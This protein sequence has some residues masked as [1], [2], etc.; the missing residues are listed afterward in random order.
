MD[1]ESFQ[2]YQRLS[3]PF[4]ETLRSS[5]FTEPD[6][7]HHYILTSD[8]RCPHL[9]PDGLCSLILELGE[10]SLCEICANHPRFFQ[11]F[12]DVEEQG[13]GIACEEA[14]RLLFTDPNP[15]TLVEEGHDEGTPFEEEALYRL[16]LDWRAECLAA[17]ADGE[18]SIY[19]RLGEVLSLGKQADNALWGAQWDTVPPEVVPGHALLWLD[20]LTELESV[21]EEWTGA[22]E[23]AFA[24]AEYPE[25]LEE[26]ALDAETR[27][28]DRLLTYYLFRF[29]LE[30]VWDA[31]AKRWADFIVFAVLTV[32]LLDFGRW[33]KNGCRF[34]SQDRQ[35][36]ARIFAKEFEYDSELA[37]KLDG[38]TE[39]IAIFGSVD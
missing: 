37:E 33:L 15:L 27:Q 14:A 19:E 9:R 31:N 36:I 1:E 24:A 35:D 23:D 4:G 6:G 29:A 25:L 22:L 10:E 28:Y 5:I 38:L 12:G 3:G 34:S 2:R 20:H 13:V 21:D 17:A 39:G 7:S 11:R 8:G 26:F 16:L 30:S 32:E 18:L